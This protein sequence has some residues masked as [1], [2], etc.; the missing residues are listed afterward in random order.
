[1]FAFREGSVDALIHRRRIRLLWGF[2]A[3]EYIKWNVWLASPTLDGLNKNAILLFFVA[4][5][6]FMFSPS[7]RPLWITG[8]SSMAGGLWARGS[9]NRQGYSG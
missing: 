2:V 6:P 9:Q 3:A 8:G 4:R 1:M 7:P 5:P